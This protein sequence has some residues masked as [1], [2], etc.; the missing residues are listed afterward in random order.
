MTEYSAPAGR[1]LLVVRLEPRPHVARDGRVHGPLELPERRPLSRDELDI[2]AKYL[3]AADPLYYSCLVNK[4]TKK[5]LKKRAVRH[6]L[7][8][9]GYMMKDGSIYLNQTFAAGTDQERRQQEARLKA[10]EVRELEQATIEVR[11]ER[12]RLARENGDVA[13]TPLGYYYET[14]PCSIC[15]VCHPVTLLT[16][17]YSPCPGSVQNKYFYISPEPASSTEDELEK[18]VSV[19]YTHYSYLECLAR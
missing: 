17:D 14:Q 19:M 16:M 12:L 2:A 1:Q 7:L 6:H 8:K 13:V 9:F 10:R 15:M 4:H 18:E 11:E 5:H 3:K